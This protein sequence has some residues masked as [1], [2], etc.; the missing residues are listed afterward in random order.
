MYTKKRYPGVYRCALF[1]VHSK[2]PDK[3]ENFNICALKSKNTQMNI[4]NLKY[5]YIDCISKAARQTGIT[6]NS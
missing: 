5:L 1:C 2:I 3:F 6:F 4:N